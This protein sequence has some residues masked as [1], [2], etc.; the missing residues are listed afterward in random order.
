MG[1]PLPPGWPVIDPDKWYWLRMS[2]HAIDPLTGGCGLRGYPDA[3][4]CL[5]GDSLIA[6]VQG[7]KQCSGFPLFLGSPWQR[8]I[9]C[10]GPFDGQASCLLY[11]P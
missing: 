9:D 6:Y 1:T 11:V 4:G 7:D 10:I 2:N 3:T 5:K 8:I